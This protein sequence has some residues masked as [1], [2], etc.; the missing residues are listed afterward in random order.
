M[1]L[2]RKIGVSAFATS[3]L[4]FKRKIINQPKC[5]LCGEANETI[6]HL[7]IQC[8]VMHK[9][10]CLKFCR[11]MQT[12]PFR[13]GK[14]VGLLLILKFLIIV[15]KICRIRNYL[16]VGQVQ[17]VNLS[18]HT[19]QERI[20]S[21]S[22]I[23]IERSAPQN[24]HNQ[25]NQIT[26]NIPRG[27]N[28]IIFSDGGYDLCSCNAGWGVAIFNSLFYLIHTDNGF[29]SG[30]PNAEAAELEDMN[31]ALSFATK[32][33]LSNVLFVSGCQ[34]VVK[35]LKGKTD[36]ILGTNYQ[37]ARVCRAKFCHLLSTLADVIWISRKANTIAHNLACKGRRD[38][39][40]I[41]S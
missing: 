4:L 33:K 31:K 34:N 16:R 35:F 15:D 10:F 2:G 9:L 21:Y 3:S 29:I 40:I 14:R 17:H 8:S 37:L 30:C 22:F 39:C 6:S 11:L 27:W 25:F 20:R 36:C 5:Y 23:L 28:F 26:T 38:F 32:K 24:S 1:L 41:S 12:L 7:F 19:I 13:N 18:I